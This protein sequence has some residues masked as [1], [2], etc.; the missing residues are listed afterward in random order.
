MQLSRAVKLA[1]HH[2]YTCFTVGVRK[3]LYQTVYSRGEDRS[4]GML[5]GMSKSALSNCQVSYSW[6]LGG[7]SLR[8]GI[9][10]VQNYP[11]ILLGKI[12]EQAI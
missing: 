11:F 9:C 2:H 5:S 6:S 1:S 7:V 8:P 10:Y 4:P 12:E 3:Y